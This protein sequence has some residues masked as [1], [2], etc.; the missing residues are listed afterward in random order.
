MRTRNTRMKLF[1]MAMALVLLAT[2]L[3]VN[4]VAQQIECSSDVKQVKAVTNPAGHVITTKYQFDT[5]NLQPLLTTTIDAG[6][7][8][9]VAHLSGQA[10]ITDNYIVFQVRVDGV[11]MEGQLPLPLFTTPVVFVSID[12][13][14][15]NDDEQF[16]D[17]TKVVAYNFFT[18]VPK[19][20]HTVEVMAAA[21]SNIDPAN[22]PSVT[23]LVLT[24]EYR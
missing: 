13:G 24:L 9:L 10:R 8:C 3:A 19:G 14:N 11:P 18:R 6:E 7:G 17:P 16:I 15:A 21:G 23:H 1:A 12:A 22:P 5:P 20:A 2:A 4:A